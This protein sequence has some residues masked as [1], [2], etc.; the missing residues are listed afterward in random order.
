MENI[1]N[2]SEPSILQMVLEMSLKL[3]KIEKK[4]EELG[5]ENSKMKEEIGK[6]SYENAKLNEKVIEMKDQMGQLKEEN[7]KMND[8]IAGKNAEFAVKIAELLHAELLQNA[9]KLVVG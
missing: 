9:D 6:M 8:Q 5:K 3:D 7:R 4:T 2:Y 1:K